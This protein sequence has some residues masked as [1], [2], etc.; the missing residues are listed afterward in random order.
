E[1]ER[2]AT[3]LV[4][5]HRLA[6]VEG[7]CT[8]AAIIASG[9]N[10]RSG[11]VREL[12][13]GGAPR[14]RLRTDDVE[15]A[16]KTIREQLP[17]IECVVEEGRLSLRASEAQAANAAAACVLSGLRVFELAEARRTLDDLYLHEVD[18]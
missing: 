13:A 17:D 12:L 9:R 7:L 16:R 6:E 2:G 15:R 11:P 10:L 5:V 1:H 3:V 18:E 8:H 14:Y 4:S